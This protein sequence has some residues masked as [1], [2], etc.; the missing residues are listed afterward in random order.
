MLTD[1]FNYLASDL[2]LRT[3]ITGATVAAPRIFPEVAPEDTR[4]PYLIFGPLK[5]G[6]TDEIM[7]AMTIQVSVFVDQHDQAAADAII[8]RLKYLVDRQD[9][10]AIPS[11]EYVIYWGK[12]VGGESYFVKETREYHRAAMF[13]FKFRTK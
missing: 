9:Q 10:I 12:H 11:T 1:F 2:T 3:L 5:E 8:K 4:T 13:A 7:D 6:S